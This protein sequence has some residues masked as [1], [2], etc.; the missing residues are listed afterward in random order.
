MQ[1]DTRRLIADVW[2][3]LRPYRKLLIISFC[4]L[5][6][7][8]PAGRLHPLFWKFV[9]DDILPNRDVHGLFVILG[10]MVGCHFLA[11]GASAVQEFFLEKAGQGMVR[12]LRV[13]AYAKL[14]AQSMRYHHDR[15]TGDLVTRVISDIDA[16]ESSVLRNIAGLIEELGSFILVAAIVIALQPA[17]GG[18]VMLPLLFAFLLIKTFNARI[19]RVYESLR[20]RLGEIGT[21]VADRL[22]GV[23][24][25]QS[26]AKEEEE[27]GRFQKIVDGHYAS[28]I[29]AVKARSIFFPI[30]GLGGF[31]SNVVMLGLGAF[32]IWRGEFTIGGLIA[33]R[34]YWWQLQ[35]PVNTL[36]RMSDT[37]QRA[38]ASAR[39]V[40]ELLNEPVEIKDAP[41]AIAWPSP[42]GR[43]TFEDV[44]F[45]YVAGKTV[46][47]HVDLH[48]APG[49]FIAIAGSSGA[50]KSTLLS[51]VPRFF[52]TT[53][54]RVLLD[55]N[56]VRDLT[57]HSIRS[58]IGLVQQETYLFNDTVLE[59]LR[60]ARPEAT[61]EE[62]QQ[63]ACRANAHLFI[64]QLP[65]GY[66]TL[67]GE[68]GVKLSGGQKQRLSLAR[69]FLAN[70]TLLLL[71]EPTSSVEPESEELIATA[72][73]ALAAERTTLLVTHRVSLLRR[74]PRILFFHEHHLAADG[75]HATLMENCPLYR[76]S[77]AL[78]EEETVVVPM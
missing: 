61:K 30:I 40:M 57:L 18:G 48:I 37:L 77:Y 69:A 1:D 38:R 70:P 23:Q 35:S 14:G 51:L 75:T 2:Q 50:G 76:E 33:Y 22:G 34:G 20:Q 25:T 5:A 24:L 28:S 31:L 10:L 11:A 73:E 65:E 45:A 46:L 3:R 71:D 54:G 8:L 59:N 74:A 67:V 49:E 78:W 21:F 36:A 60:Y 15:R 53:S 26:Y 29:D 64:D 43:I 7:A 52:D 44:S 16:M 66:A 47:D 19:K 42:Q 27:V 17:I 62:V 68:R 55:G 63:A 13:E 4:F 32:F 58:E 6:I 9:V 12:D 56:D 39:R 41:Q 72:I